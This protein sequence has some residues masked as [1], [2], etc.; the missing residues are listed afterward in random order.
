[1]IRF[2]AWLAAIAVMFLVVLFLVPDRSSV[3]ALGP[4]LEIEVVA[5][6]EPILPATG[7]VIGVGDLTTG[8]VH[9]PQRVEPDPYVEDAAPFVPDELTE[10]PYE[11]DALYYRQYVKYR[12]AKNSRAPKDYRAIVEPQ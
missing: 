12:Q 9:S 11:E 4:Q 10:P 7:E 2:L 5:P 1:M 3:V 6:T 8:Y